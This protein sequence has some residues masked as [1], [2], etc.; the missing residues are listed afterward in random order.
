MSHNVL[1]LDELAARVRQLSDRIEKT[2]PPK[3]RIA[4]R[5]EDV[6][7]KYSATKSGMT[8]IYIGDDS[9]YDSF[10]I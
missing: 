1:L 5:L 7:E 10:R 8:H 4:D 9:S 3:L 2:V 6:R